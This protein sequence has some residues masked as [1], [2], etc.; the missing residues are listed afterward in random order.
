[1]HIPC[2]LIHPL[3]LIYFAIVYTNLLFKRYITLC[4]YRFVHIQLQIKFPLKMIELTRPSNSTTNTNTTNTNNATNSM[5]T[6]QSKP[7]YLSTKSAD[8]NG[9]HNKGTLIRHLEDLF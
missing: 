6:T 2:I 3:I 5:L 4:L 8:S 7:M 1:M 9:D